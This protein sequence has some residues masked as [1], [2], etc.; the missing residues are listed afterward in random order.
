MNAPGVLAYDTETRPFR[1][2]CGAP[3]IA[4]VTFAGDSGAG[5]LH[6][7]QA[8]PAIE[9]WLSSAEILVGQF[10]SYDMAVV[11]AKWPDLFPAI[12]AAY[13]ADRVTCTKIR[14]Q[15]ADIARGCFRGYAGSDSVWVKIEYRLESIARR[16]L[17]IQMKKDGWRMRYGEVVDVPLEGWIDAA[18]GMQLD[19]A[20]RLASIT[21]SGMN[22]EKASKDGK[23]FM[24]DLRA[25]VS[26]PPGQ[27][28][29]YP[30][31]DAKITRAVYEAQERTIPP[32]V[33]V[34]QFRQARANFALHLSSTWGLRT[35]KAG[36]DALR[37]ATEAALV[38]VTA[39]LKA[40]GLVRE[41]GSRDTKKAIAHMLSVCGWIRLEGVE[42]PPNAPKDWLPRVPG[43]RPVC[44]GGK[45]FYAAPG[46]EYL[47]L[48][49]TKTREVC[50]D[51]DACEACDD[52]L[53]ADYAE[54]T[55]LDKT[56]SADLPM[57][58][59]GCYQPVHCRY[60]LAASGRVT[61][62]GPNIQNLR[63]F[64]GIREC[65]VPREGRVFIQGD[66]PQ[67][68]LYTLAQCCYAWLG[69]STLGEMLKKG[70]D[71]HTAFAAK[72][73]GMTYEEGVRLNKA[74]DKRFSKELRQIAK[75][76]NFGKPGGLGP[77]KLVKL[78]AS[79][80]Y[81]VAITLDQA[82]EYGKVW[83]ETF[84]EMKDY[85]AR[86]NRLLVPT[87]PKG[88]KLATIVLP[89]T[90]FVRGG[91]MYCAACNTGFQGLGAACAK[92]GMWLVARAEY[93]DQSSPLYGARTVAM[94][95]DELIAECDEAVCH[96]AAHELVRLMV[97]GANEFLPDVPIAL[98][99][100]EPTVM[101]RWSKDAAQV[102]VNGRLVPWEGKA[103]A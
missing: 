19:A 17:G 42:E 26:D 65:F 8:R 88:Q 34:D 67:L 18:K 49:L 98:S 72:L 86:V 68:E 58:E 11:A 30:I 99:K 76:F 33:L 4:C 2:G 25:I 57:L 7:S 87:G 53:L 97:V 12:F 6:Q 59:K 93:A 64:P 14:Q 60:D 91:A 70:I 73:G 29:E 22:E 62:S 100:M 13:D 50:L 74:K 36:V 39:R 55:G 54:Y 24:K 28:I 41:D 51:A 10:I 79:D 66:L 46:D 94:V 102:W 81:K 9:V 44:G 89:G 63:K 101:R 47:P 77:A 5:I 92:H 82:K 3:E 80:A 23:Q 20:R 45:H 40:S 83:L 35:N 32:F 37:V 61:C 71:P 84:P 78:G 1:A 16:L 85:F 31:D 95:H 21:A 15:L 75:V 90:G 52:D 56:L 96:E 38:E 48:R 43:D 69:H 27:F 103:A